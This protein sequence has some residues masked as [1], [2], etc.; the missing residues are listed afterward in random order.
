MS[1]ITLV[2]L[3]GQYG[4]CTCKK[5]KGVIKAGEKTVIEQVKQY[6][7]HPNYY[8]EQCFKAK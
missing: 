1:R 2:E 5:C 4:Q 3:T 6:P 8:H 7:M